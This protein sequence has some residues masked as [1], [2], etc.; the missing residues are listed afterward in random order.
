MKPIK[1]ILLPNSQVK[2]IYDNGGK[3]NK[4]ARGMLMKPWEIEATLEK[5]KTCA[6]RIIN[7]EKNYSFIKMHKDNNNYVANFQGYIKSNRYTKY[8]KCK[9]GKPGD[10]LYIRKNYNIRRDQAEEWLKIKNIRCERLQD[11]TEEDAEKEGIPEC[12]PM[13]EFFCSY[14]KGYGHI[15]VGPSIDECPN[16]DTRKK[17]FANAWDEINANRKDPK[18]KKILPYAWKDNPWVFVIDY[19]LFFVGRSQNE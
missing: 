11:I 8:I 7:I 14:C 9:Q 5:R 10:L 3:E 4:K 2:I 13:Q 16:C 19:E 15:L 6:R 18:T 12:Y 1:I 17:R